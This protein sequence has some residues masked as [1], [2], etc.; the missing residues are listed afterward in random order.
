MRT[1]FL[2]ENGNVEECFAMEL[3][4]M[5]KVLHNCTVTMKS[6]GMYYSVLYSKHTV[7]L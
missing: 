7:R 3:A 2:G 6:Y 1:E 4:A 5:R